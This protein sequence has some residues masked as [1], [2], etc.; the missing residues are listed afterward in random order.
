MRLTYFL[1][2]ALLFVGCCNSS[3]QSLNLMKAE[4]FRTTVEGK[5]TDLYTLTNGTLTMQ[6]TSFGARVVSLWA[7]DREGNMADIV[8]GYQ[9]IDRYINNTGERFLGSVVGRVANRIGA[10]KFTLEGTEYTT[11]KN[12]NG[13]TLHGGDKGLDMVVWDVVSVAESA[14][15]LHYIAPDGQDGFPGNLDITMTYTLTPE[16]EFRVDYS[17][18]TDKTTVVNLSHHSFFNL[19]G[20]AGGT[21]TDHI[22]QIDADSITP[23]DENLIPTGEIRPVAG[24]AYDFRTAHAIGEMINSSDEQLAAGRGYDMNWVLSRADDGEV[25]R[26][27]TLYEPQSGRAMDVLTD[28]IALQFYSGNFFDG[29]Y[30]GK[31]GKHLSFRE[32]VVFESQRYPDAPNHENFPS[33]VLR[34]DEEYRHTCIYRLYTK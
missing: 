7:P 10:G 33:V 26:V 25:V 27:L 9:N 4:D 30:T 29:S 2:V 15:V 8:L 14:I 13:Q 12:N 23:T 28:Q 11:P 34:P 21:I 20:E 24:T 31:Y 6:V 5:T 1:A 3:T 17:A 16:N 18:R 22:L 32:S 19:K